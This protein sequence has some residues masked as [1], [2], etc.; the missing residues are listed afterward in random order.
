MIIIIVVFMQSVTAEQRY[1]R[2]LEKGQHARSCEIQG[3]QFNQGVVVI[4]GVHRGKL[5]KQQCS[6]WR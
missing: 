2:A 6:N 3:Q 4:V 1:P 5:V